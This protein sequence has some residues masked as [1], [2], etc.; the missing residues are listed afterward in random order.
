MLGRASSMGYL[1]VVSHQGPFAVHLCPDH[2]WLRQERPLHAVSS[3]CVITKCRAEWD[4]Q[5]DMCSLQDV[6]TMAHSSQ[7]GQ[8]SL[9]PGEPDACNSSLA[10]LKLDQFVQHMPVDDTL[11]VSGACFWGPIA[12]DLENARFSIGSA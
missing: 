5:D 1:M 10:C 9:P 7:H 6:V 12:E 3:Q 8:H 4:R 2:T 11:L